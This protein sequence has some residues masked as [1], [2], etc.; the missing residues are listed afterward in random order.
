MR[1]WT[2]PIAMDSV[3][4]AASQTFALRVSFPLKKRRVSRNRRFRRSRWS[5]FSRAI[6]TVP[7]LHYARCARKDHRPPTTEYRF[8]EA[9]NRVLPY[10]PLLQAPCSV[11]LKSSH[12]DAAVMKA[13]ETEARPVEE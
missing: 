5:I 10:R 13:M 9:I 6:V 4:S 8:A 7:T 3:A 2:K 1:I 11:L 12:E